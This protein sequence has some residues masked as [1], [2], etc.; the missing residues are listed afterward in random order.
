M[1][2]E[3]FRCDEKVKN[4]K[5]KFGTELGHITMTQI[6]IFISF[7]P[8]PQQQHMYMRGPLCIVARA[9]CTFCRLRGL[10]ARLTERWGP[11]G[12]PGRRPARRGEAEGVRSA[13]AAWAAAGP[14]RARRRAGGVGRGRGKSLAVRHRSLC[15]SGPQLHTVHLHGTPTP[16]VLAAT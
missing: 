15:L 10:P 3:K 16:C 12:R 13:Y 8:P 14:G 1:C 7:H 4:L 6:R 11:H 2:V 5:K 9:G